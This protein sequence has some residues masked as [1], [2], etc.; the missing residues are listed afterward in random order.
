MD[1]YTF[2]DVLLVPASNHYASRRD[3]ETAVTDRTG[4]LTLELPLISA[5]MDTVTEAP[6]ANF[7]AK[8]GAMGSLHRFMDIQKNVDEY[9]KCPQ[10]TFV[11][12][13]I[14]DAEM[15]RVQA[16]MDAGATY[17]MIDVAHA[18]ARYVGNQIKR[19][20]E[21]IKDRCLAAG[22]VAT[23]AGADYLASCGADV[24]KVGIGGGSACTT[25]IKTGFGVPTLF[26]VKDC[27]RVDRSIVADGGLRSPGDIVK[28]LAFGDEFVMLGGMLSGTRVTPGE[29]QTDNEG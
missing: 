29:V 8:N 17:F 16:L 13:G 11:S 14:S 21:L 10:K 3:V 15:E 28:A 5:N 1:A 25:R 24:I 23:Y 12:C 6:M 22:N 2:D 26:S 20:R 4:K 7:M 18:H 9:K 19:M 27:A